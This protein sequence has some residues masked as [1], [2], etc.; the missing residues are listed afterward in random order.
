[1]VEWRLEPLIRCIMEKDCMPPS[2]VRQTLMYAVTFP[3]EIKMLGNDFLENY[4][5][6]AY[7]WVGLTS[8]NITQ[9]VIWVDQCDKWS[10]T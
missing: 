1:M 6:L 5:F 4:I 7:G 10:F 3:K 2:G 8:E 9:K